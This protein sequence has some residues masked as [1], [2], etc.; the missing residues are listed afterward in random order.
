MK[1]IEAHKH[2]WLGENKQHFPEQESLVRLAD[3][4]V[5]IRYNVADAYFST[6]E[7]FYLSIAEVQWIDGKPSKRDEQEK[8]LIE[9]W[10]FLAIE[11]RLLE[12]DMRDIE[13]DHEFGDEY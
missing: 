2:W 11:E 4:R 5:F 1:K 7:Q 6:F 12:E 10:N 13:N 8:I 3:P 9:A